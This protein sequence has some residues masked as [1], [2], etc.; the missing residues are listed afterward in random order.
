MD[1]F[2][3]AGFGTAAYC[4]L[5]FTHWAQSGTRQAENCLETIGTRL[6]YIKFIAVDV[7]DDHRRPLAPP[8]RR[9]QILQD[10]LN[11]FAQAGTKPVIYTNRGDW[12][13]LFILYTKLF[14]AYPLWTGATWSFEEYVDAAGSLACGF[15]YQSLLPA[16]HGGDGIPSLTPFTGFGSWTAQLGH[17][18]DIGNGPWYSTCL[19]GTRVD[20]DVF[21][22]SLFQ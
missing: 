1:T 13:V 8:Q 15:G 22:P 7:E 16:R 14:T 12:F 19:F 17:Q 10:A 20:F 11:T 2:S 18:Y 3:G 21:D 4:F 5:H 6:G 9:L